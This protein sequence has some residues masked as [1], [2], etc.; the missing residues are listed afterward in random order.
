MEETEGNYFTLPY[1]ISTVI[2]QAKL[3]KTYDSTMSI[4]AYSYNADSGVLVE[5]D[6][7][8]QSYVGYG[9][10]ILIDIKDA[11][12]FSWD[13]SIY[14]SYTG[15]TFSGNTGGDDG[16]YASSVYVEIVYKDGSIEILEE[17][18]EN[19][20]ISFYKE[21]ADVGIKFCFST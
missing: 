4:G 12:L 11:G 7:E 17:G 18:L 5:T 6:F 14:N 16:G 8:A 3:S 21:V 1:D 2:I 20:Q 10:Y 13:Y 9:D 15:E 19:R